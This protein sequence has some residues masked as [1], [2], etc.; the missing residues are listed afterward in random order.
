MRRSESASSRGD[1]SQHVQEYVYTKRRLCTIHYHSD[2]FRR[3]MHISSDHGD[4]YLEHIP[5]HVQQHIRRP[6]AAF[7]LSSVT[8]PASLASLP[9]SLPASRVTTCLANKDISRRS[10]SEYH[11]RW[12]AVLGGFRRWVG[13]RRKRSWRGYVGKPTALRGVTEI[14]REEGCRLFIAIY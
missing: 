3:E 6:T 9:A 11:G 13:D 5:S 2:N 12:E 1:I 8:G 4:E 14:S 7:S 10:R